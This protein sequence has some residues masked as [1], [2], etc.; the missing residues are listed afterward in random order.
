[1]IGCLLLGGEL[2]NASGQSGFSDSN[3]ILEQRGD[4]DV[5]SV[6]FGIIPKPDDI[7]K[8]DI[9]S[10]TCCIVFDGK[11]LPNAFVVSAFDFDEH[12]VAQY[13]DW[14]ATVSPP[15]FP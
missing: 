11:N 2:R 6:A 13:S 14:F 10:D 9:E 4:K 1:M 5:D 12:S 3:S 7:W 8:A 15:Q